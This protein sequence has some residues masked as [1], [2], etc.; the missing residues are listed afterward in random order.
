MSYTKGVSTGSLSLSASSSFNASFTPNGAFINA[1]KC[2]HPTVADTNPY[3]Q[4]TYQGNGIAEYS[5]IELQGRPDADQWVTE[6]AIKYT[7]DGVNWLDYNSGNGIQT[8]LTDRNTPKTITFSPTIRALA[9]QIIPKQATGFKAMRFEVE[10]KPIPRSTI[11]NFEVGLVSTRD[12]NFPKLY[13]GSVADRRYEH[14]VKFTTGFIKPPIVVCGIH[15]LHF[16]NTKDLKFSIIPHD[17]TDEGFTILI[18]S[19]DNGQ[20][21]EISFNWIAFE[22][23]N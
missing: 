20:M 19:W 17:I 12:G 9:I 10:Y 3:V 4:T 21:E 7:K 15:N 11:T 5:K 16:S 1:N 2:W 13:D 22:S 18:R 8:G 23:S 6:V 14:P